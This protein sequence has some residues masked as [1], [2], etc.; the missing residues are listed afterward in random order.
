TGHELIGTSYKK[1]PSEL[2]AKLN[3]STVSCMIL[4]ENRRG[5]LSGNSRRRAETPLFTRVSALYSIFIALLL[6]YLLQSPYANI[7]LCIDS[8]VMYLHFLLLFDKT[9]YPL[10]YERPQNYC[11][12][13]NVRMCRVSFQYLHVLGGL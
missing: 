4:P 3:R 1:S 8:W 13:T 2:Q 11:L 5:R 10:I 9:K 6:H 12:D 7:E